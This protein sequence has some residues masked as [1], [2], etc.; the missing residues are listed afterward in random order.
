MTF[1]SIEL[2]LLV[3]GRRQF[4]CL[5]LRQLGPAD[6]EALYAELVSGMI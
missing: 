5:G 6:A 1:M 4:R 2:V 3:S